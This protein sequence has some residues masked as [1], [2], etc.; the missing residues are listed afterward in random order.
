[1]DRLKAAGSLEYTIVVSA[2]STDP[3]SLQFLAPLFGSGGGGVVHE[4]WKTLSYR[5]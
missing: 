1:M 5:L 4:A 2:P 3:A